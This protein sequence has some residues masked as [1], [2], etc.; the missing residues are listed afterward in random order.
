MRAGV[1]GPVGVARAS[2]EAV[3]SLN[4]AT[5]GGGYAQPGDVD[6]VVAALGTAARR[7]PQALTQ[8]A[9]WLG[10]EAEAGRLGDDRG[11]QGVAVTVA[12]VLSWLDVAAARA[13]A[14][15]EALDAAQNATSH[16]TGNPS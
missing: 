5:L 10:A 2:A 4:Q 11:P 14:L 9:R 12:E 3:R 13:A 1:P 8:A 6:A 15:G 7:L 16:L